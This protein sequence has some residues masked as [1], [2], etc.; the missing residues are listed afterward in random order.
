LV[1]EGSVF[2]F[3]VAEELLASIEAA[4]VDEEGLAPGPVVED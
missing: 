4:L 1:D 3:N 2:G